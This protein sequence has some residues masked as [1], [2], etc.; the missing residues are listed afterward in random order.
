MRE[1][2]ARTLSYRMLITRRPRI[3]FRRVGGRREQEKRA[4]DARALLSADSEKVKLEELWSIIK[5]LYNKH[6][7]TKRSK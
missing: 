2:L 4:G 6:C 3:F 1:R 5:K 7:T